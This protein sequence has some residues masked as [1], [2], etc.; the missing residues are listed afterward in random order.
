MAQIIV[1]RWICL[2]RS[3]IAPISIAE[4]C[5]FNQLTLGG[6]KR[7]FTRVNR[8]GD[9]LDRQLAN[10]ESVLLDHDNFLVCSDR[11]DSHPV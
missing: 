3:K 2:H 10:T 6:T 7:I 8:A 5:L 11:D 4:P 1:N 9:R